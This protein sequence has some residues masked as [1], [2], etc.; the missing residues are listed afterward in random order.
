MYKK[1][2]PY[3]LNNWR[4]ITLLNV[5][6][7][8]IAHCLSQR[9]KPLLPKIVNTDQNGFIQGQNINYS[10]RLIQDII[11]YSNKHNIKGAILFLDFAKAYDTIEWEFMFSVIEHFG[12]KNSFL[13]WVKIPYNK[14]SCKVINNGWISEKIKISRGIKQGCPLSSLIFVLIV[15]ILAQK[16]REEKMLHGIKVKNEQKKDFKIS[17]LADDTTL[18]LK[19]KSDISKA[20]NI[21]EIFG[22]L[23]GLVLN[24]SK[25]LGM[26][27]GKIAIPHNFEN[28]DWTQTK[29]KA[30]GIYFGVNTENA[31]Y[32]N[33][34]ERISKMKNI[35]ASWNQRKLTMI[36]K[37]QIV[38]SLLIP[39]LTYFLSAIHIPNHILKEIEKLLYKFIW[40]GK[41]EKIKR[42]YLIRIY[43]EGGLKMTDLESHAKTI[44]ITWIKKLTDKTDSQWKVIP[45]FYLNELSPNLLIF[46]MNLNNIKQIKQINNIPIFYQKILQAW[47]EIKGMKPQKIK[48]AIDIGKEI[49]WG[50]SNITLKGKVL[51]FP[52]WINSNIIYIKDILDADGKINDQLIYNKLKNKQNWLAEI[53][54]IKKNNSQKIT[55]HHIFKKTC[56]P[57]RK[58]MLTSKMNI[59]KLYKLHKQNQTSM[60]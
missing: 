27:L 52:K 8:I 19:T 1:N 33:W 49:I 40:D 28:I 58:H 57:S 13:K 48:T 30:L 41:S 9:I 39:Q 34:N 5:D 12:F 7:K 54:T 60:M 37:I 50:N 38:K 10:I 51:I 59:S 53:M 14:I 43:E 4:P 23:S 3:D 24:K 56:E 35:I 18:F 32:E 44:Y 26:K 42:R 11:E 25:T 15:E 17:Q 55:F 6:Y 16:I 2:N 45:H 22:S 36:G 20:L 31:S 21:I 47:I 46:K 29:I